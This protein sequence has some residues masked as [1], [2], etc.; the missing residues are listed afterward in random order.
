M[1]AHHID[2]TDV[3]TLFRTTTVTRFNTG[4][5]LAAGPPEAG[6]SN[7]KRVARVFVGFL[8]FN[9]VHLCDAEVV[10]DGKRGPVDACSYWP[11]GSRLDFQVT[12]LL[13]EDIYREQ[14]TSKRVMLKF[15]EAAALAMIRDALL[16]KTPRPGNA[17]TRGDITLLFDC[18][19]G[20]QM[21]VPTTTVIPADFSRWTRRMGWESIWLVGGR[22]AVRVDRLR[23]ELWLPM[24]WKSKRWRTVR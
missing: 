9:G 4:E 1:A 24:K 13:P 12:R 16:R 19:G 15:Q 21:V 3:R 20:V 17:L 18:T 7:V 11:D 2:Q 5:Y 14:A 8:Q 22:H 10:K 23:G 6:E